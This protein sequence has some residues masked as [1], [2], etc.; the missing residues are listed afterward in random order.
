M[1]SLERLN[2]ISVL[3]AYCSETTYPPDH[4]TTGTKYSTATLNK[5]PV[6]YSADRATNNFCASQTGSHAVTTVADTLEA[7]P[8]QALVNTM[9][10]AATTTTVSIISQETQQDPCFYPSKTIQ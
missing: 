10:T 8:A 7:A 9:G 5:Q 1:Q 4:H 3:L 6:I 2:F